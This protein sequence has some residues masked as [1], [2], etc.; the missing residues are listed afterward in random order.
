MLVM[1]LTVVAF[2]VLLP[3]FDIAGLGT[4]CMVDVAATFTHSP[5]TKIRKKLH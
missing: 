1:L 4:T 5:R 2:E 3:F